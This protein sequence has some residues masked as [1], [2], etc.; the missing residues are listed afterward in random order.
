MNL[1]SARE[2]TLLLEKHD[3]FFKKNLGQNFLV[4]EAIADRIAAASRESVRGPGPALAVEIGPGA[5]ALT[6]KLAGLFDRVVAIE[7]D[8]RLLPVLEESLEDLDN[9]EIVLKDALKFDFSALGESCPGFRFAVCSNLPYYITSEIL[10]R[11]L[12]SGLPL[13]SITVLIQKEASARLTALPGTP[14]FGSITAAIRYYAASQR[15]FTVS[16]GN[17]I[18]K[19][20]VDS[21]VLRLLPNPEKPVSPLDESLF[22]QVIRASFS[23]RRKTLSNSLSS[24]FSGRFSKD[25]ILK[26][27][28]E[29]GIDPARRGETL[30]LPEFC[31]ISDILSK[32]EEK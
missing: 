17:F 24:Y 20:K 32:T 9:V 31:L 18:P 22:F 12:E 2:M 11:L 27:L 21:A 29:A 15:L 23:E 4:S 5:G 26:A 13:Q 7:I 10:M 6:R 25:V 3:F 8:P 16:P 19:P 28:E 1:Y 30:D 14:E